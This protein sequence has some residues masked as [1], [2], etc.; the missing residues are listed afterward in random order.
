VEVGVGIVQDLTVEGDNVQQIEV[1]T[2]ILTDL[3]FL[4]CTSNFPSRKTFLWYT[5]FQ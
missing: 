5:V 1:L 2:F 3:R 4:T